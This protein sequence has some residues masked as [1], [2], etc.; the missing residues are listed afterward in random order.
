MK[1]LEYDPVDKYLRNC[2]KNWSRQVPL[3]AHGKEKLFLQVGHHVPETPLHVRVLQTVLWLI[4]HLILIPVDYL[5]TP[6]VYSVEDD[7]HADL[8][9]SR[10]D[11]SLAVRSMTNDTL[12]HG[13][14]IFTYIT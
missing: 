9:H 11:L 3:P 14:E 6:V 12:S 1:M 4:Y 8:Y 5:L 10:L 2:L 13:I 7:V